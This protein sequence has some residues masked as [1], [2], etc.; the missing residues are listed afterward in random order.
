MIGFRVCEARVWLRLLTAWPPRGCAFVYR[1]RD[2]QRRV[3][4]SGASRR[5][6]LACARA[7]VGAGAMA[8]PTRGC[9]VGAPES[10]AATL[11]LLPLAA[12][13]CRA[14]LAARR[15]ACDPCSAIILQEG[16]GEREG[17]TCEHTSSRD[18]QLVNGGERLGARRN[19]T[20]KGKQRVWGGALCSR[21]ARRP[22]LRRAPRKT[23]HTP[24]AEPLRARPRPW[25][26]RKPRR[27]ARRAPEE[28][29][30]RAVEQGL[31]H[32]RRGADAAVARAARA[33]RHPPPT[34]PPPC[35]RVSTPCAP[36]TRRRRC[37]R[38]P[39]KWSKAAAKRNK[40]KGL[41][42]WHT[43][44]R[45]FAAQGDLSGSFSTPSVDVP[46]WRTHNHS[47]TPL[48]GKE[49]HPGFGSLRL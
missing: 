6:T 19:A 39:Q 1:Q 14:M 30:R 24:L 4:P 45:S 38:R 15:C 49:R 33:Q 36:D 12:V 22:P 47:S 27:G 5:T 37:A 18:A 21:R 2:R 32:A 23:P 25:A 40:T 20:R 8:F 34:F 35:P 26:R 44:H 10:A 29:R 46:L 43:E 3:L 48:R 13:T 7:C 9:G 11:G 31:L 17:E 42:T 41:A 16:G 28:R